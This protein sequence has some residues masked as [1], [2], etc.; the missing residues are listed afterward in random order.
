M[1]TSFTI[2]PKMLKYIRE[3]TNKSIEKYLDK[4]YINTKSIEKKHNSSTFYSSW[5]L[6]SFISFLAGYSFR[7]LENYQTNKN[8]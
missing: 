1:Y 6:V 4:N 7:F 3:S 5:Q 2:S 8:L